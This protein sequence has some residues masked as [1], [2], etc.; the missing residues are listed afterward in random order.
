MGQ[1]GIY[2]NKSDL[3]EWN[4]TVPVK[5]YPINEDSVNCEIIHKNTDQQVCLT[6]DVSIK[7]LQPPA[8]ATPGDVV[9]RYNY[10]YY[11]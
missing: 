9:I 6:Q 4:G 1:T 2:A 7:Y 5:D 10:I 3:V 8:P 11:S